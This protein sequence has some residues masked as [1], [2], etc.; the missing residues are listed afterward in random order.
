MHLAETDGR[1]EIAFSRDTRIA[2]NS[3]ALVQSPHPLREREDLWITTPV[4]ICIRPD[5]LQLAGRYR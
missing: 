2:E 1:N 5:L 3:I 4:K